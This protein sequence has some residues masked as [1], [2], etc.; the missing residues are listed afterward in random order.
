MCAEKASTDVLRGELATLGNSLICI[1]DME[2]G[3]D[4]TDDD[5]GL[6]CPSESAPES[7]VPGA[8]MGES[9]TALELI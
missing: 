1:I 2:R 4:T 7:E 5:A 9:E 3:F 8:S 6:D